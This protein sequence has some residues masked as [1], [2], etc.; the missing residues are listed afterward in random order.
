MFSIRNT[1]LGSGIRRSRNAVRARAGGSDQQ[2]ADAW[3]DLR[4]EQL[5]ARHESIVWQRAG[6]VLHVEAREPEQ[7]GGFRNLRRNCFR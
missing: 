1:K 7:L 5:D 4:A 3:D 6:A 2:L